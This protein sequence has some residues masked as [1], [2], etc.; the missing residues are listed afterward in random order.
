MA[1]ILDQYYQKKQQSLPQIEAGNLSYEDVLH[2]QELL[3]RISVLESCMAFCKTA[4]VTKDVTAMSFHY[5]VVDALIA[6]MVQERQIGIPADEKLKKQRSAAL[7]NLQ[8]IVASFRNQF[9]GF[10]PTTPQSYREAVARMINTILNAWL[11]YRYTYI[12]F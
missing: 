11:Q 12:P 7:N 9:R 5:Q 10:A 3:Y 8:V 2:Y 4:P 6:N 1:T